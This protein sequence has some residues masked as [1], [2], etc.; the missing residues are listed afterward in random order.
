MLHLQGCGGDAATT[1]MQKALS[2]AVLLGAM[3]HLQGCGGDAATT[4]APP[5]DT[6]T[7]AAPATTASPTAAP[8][9]FKSS[10]TLSG[11]TIEEADTPEMKAAIGKGLADS[12]G[13]EA[14]AVEVTGF[15][16][17]RRLS[18]HVTGTTLKC[19]YT[20]TVAADAAAPTAPS[21]DA[22]LTSI[23]AAIAADTNIPADVRTKAASSMT[24]SAIETGFTEVV[25][26]TSTNSTRR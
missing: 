17:G 5:V 13:L 1:A 9:V 19:L 16:A 15:E 24:V 14:S 11:L 20:V 23:Q 25:D 3:L 18:S 12:M 4:A 2:L 8:K 10:V 6:D 21:A 26:D 22:A 7:T